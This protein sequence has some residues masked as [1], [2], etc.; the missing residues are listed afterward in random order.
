MRLRVAA[1]PA[2]DRVLGV[3]QRRVQRP[4]AFRRRRRRLDRRLDQPHLGFG[5]IVVSEIE[6]LNMLVNLV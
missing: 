6:V 2:C 1:L 4:P 5:R 3:H